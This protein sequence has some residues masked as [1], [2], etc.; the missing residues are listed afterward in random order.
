M[1]VILANDDNVLVTTKKDR[2]MHRSKLVDDLWFLTKP[3][4]NGYDMA[5]FTP[6]LEYVLP[7]SRK[8]CNEILTLSDEMYNGYLKYVLPIDTELTCEPGEIEITLSFLLADLDE[9]GKP[10]QR[11]RKFSPTTIPVFPVTAWS[12]IIPDSALSALD[13]R[14]I[15]TDAQLK[16]LAELN[17]GSA[18]IADGL[19]YDKVKN[20]LQLKAGDELIGNRVALVSGEGSIDE[21]IK[22]GLPV[23]DFAT[24]DVDSGEDS[25]TDDDNIVEF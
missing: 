19:D 24:V 7:I 6:S 15:K 25:E 3:T 8:Y 20:E 12:D 9:N 23:V 5:I 16:A 1:Y 17:L 10:V 18:T 11:V 2:I 14:I 22:D 21:A 4:Y 13:Q